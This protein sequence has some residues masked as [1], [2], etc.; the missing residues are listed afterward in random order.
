MKNIVRHCLC[1]ALA[2]GMLGATAPATP[3]LANDSQK[4]AR[5]MY[6]GVVRN[7]FGNCVRTKWDADSDPCAPPP[8]PPKPR[9]QAPPPPPPPPVVSLEQRTIYFDFDSAKLSPDAV[10]KLDALVNHIKGTKQVIQAGVIGYA[11]EIGNEAYNLKLSQKRAD[12]VEQ[13]I[14]SRVNIDTRVLELRGL[15][16]S[17]S[18]TDCGDVRDRKQKIACLAQDRRVEV[19]FKYRK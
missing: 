1:A 5:D 7:T 3:A 14:A 6:D 9:V 17:N 13:Y 8:P 16:E 12:A 11:D 2:L 10:A 18:V 19:A 4:A 15:G